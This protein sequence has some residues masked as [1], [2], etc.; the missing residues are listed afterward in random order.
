MKQFKSHIEYSNYTIIGFLIITLSIVLLLC[1]AA[2]SGGSVDAKGD[3]LTGVHFIDD[4]NRMLIG[5]R[6]VASDAIVIKK[7]QTDYLPEESTR[8]D[9]FI[10]DGI[11]KGLDVPDI[12]TPSSMTKFAVEDGVTPE[13]IFTNGACAVF[14]PKERDG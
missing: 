1:V 3:F 7:G 13:L 10:K 9:Q 5:T 12:F 14:S 2:F 4:S 8:L 6:M 11:I